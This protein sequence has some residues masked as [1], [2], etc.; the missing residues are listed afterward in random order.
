MIFMSWLTDD[1]RLRGVLAPATGA[2]SGAV[3]APAGAASG[4][5][6]EMPGGQSANGTPVQ[7]L[8]SHSGAEPALEP[9]AR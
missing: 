8:D 7:V 4:R 1:P 3:P 9:Q 2:A 6:L 5:A